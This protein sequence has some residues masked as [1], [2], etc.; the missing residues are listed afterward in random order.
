MAQL[1]SVHCMSMGPWWHYVL[2]ITALSLL[3]E[4]AHGGLSPDGCM[5]GRELG[6]S[7]PDPR[8][9]SLP[10]T[11]SFQINP[12][13]WQGKS[14]LKGCEL[15]GALPHWYDRVIP[16]KQQCSFSPE[17]RLCSSPRVGHTHCIGDASILGWSGQMGMVSSVGALQSISF[18]Y[19]EIFT[20]KWSAF[21]L[22]KLHFWWGEKT[23]C[24][25]GTVQ[26]AHF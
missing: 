16:D 13:S 20:L 12:S 26:V 21:I 19:R 23:Y 8:Y 17:L 14:V 24:I 7:V 10:A 3:E 9:L 15:W 22:I 5:E 18:P 6:L 11:G 2:P 1:Y 4:I 25:S